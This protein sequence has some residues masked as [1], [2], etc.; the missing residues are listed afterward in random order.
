MKKSNV[1]ALHLGGSTSGV[2]TYQKSNSF[3]ALLRAISE[4][5][6]NV[7]TA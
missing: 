4:K 3:M 2:T 1:K 7:I 5:G 6:F